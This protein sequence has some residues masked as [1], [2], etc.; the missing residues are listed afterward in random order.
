M[1]YSAKKLKKCEE[2]FEKLCQDVF[3]YH[4]DIV[5]EIMKFYLEKEHG[6]QLELA[7]TLISDDDF[8]DLD[9]QNREIHNSLYAVS[10]VT[11]IFNNKL[12]HYYFVKRYLRR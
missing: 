2:K 5:L 12:F 11:K 9:K 3:P 7:K 8:Q 10:T 6:N 4:Y 1:V